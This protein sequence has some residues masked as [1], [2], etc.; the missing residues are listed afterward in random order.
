MA[1]AVRPYDH[2]SVLAAVVLDVEVGD[3]AP[4]GR[5]FRL[6]ELLVVFLV[7]PGPGEHVRPASQRLH[8]D[9]IAPA[10]VDVL[11]DR[12]RE[13]ECLPIRGPVRADVVSGR[14][15][16]ESMPVDADDPDSSLRPEREQPA[17]GRERRLEP[18]PN[19]SPETAAVGARNPDRRRRVLIR[20]GAVRDRAAVARDG[21]WREPAAG[22][23]QRRKTRAVVGE[24]VHPRLA[25]AVAADQYPLPGHRSSCR[26]SG[27]GAAGAHGAEEHCCGQALRAGGGASRG[28]NL[29]FLV[30][31]LLS[32]G[33]A[34]V[35]GN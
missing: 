8:D 1:F 28:R 16:P 11:G 34:P 29:S 13:D 24:A 31:I 19:E 32:A 26:S 2:Q 18:F 7:P 23:E 15:A 33:N 4:A 3:P 27:G 17:V 20:V 9:R 22:W 35:T 5:P 10:A 14:D 6:V 12:P 30:A 25:V 21:H